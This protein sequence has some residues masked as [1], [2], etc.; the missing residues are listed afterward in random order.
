MKNKVLV[1]VVFVLL[2]MPAMIGATE[3]NLNLTYPVFPGAPNIN[4]GAA[5]TDQSISALVAWFYVFIVGISGLAAFVMIIW[6]G[7]E[8]MTS[9]GNPTRTSEA[10]DKIQKALLGL[11]LILA[12]Y[13]I[14]QV[15]NPELTILREPG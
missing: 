5:N 12:S 6:G 10:K 14:L 7:V 4:A 8:Y 11:L 15:I 1:F 3:V 13:L 2:V 9:A